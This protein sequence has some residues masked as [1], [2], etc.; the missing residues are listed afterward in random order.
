MEL[1]KLREKSPEALNTHLGELH[2][3]SFAFRMQ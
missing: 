1:K 3:E 2:K